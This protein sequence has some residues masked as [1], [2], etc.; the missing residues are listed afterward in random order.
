VRAHFVSLASRNAGRIVSPFVPWAVPYA[1]AAAF[2]ASHMNS[3]DRWWTRITVGNDE[4]D[5]VVPYRSQVYPGQQVVNYRAVD[6]V[7]HTAEADTRLSAR[8]IRRVL[9]LNVGVEVR[10]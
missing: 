1:A 8:S 2:V 7:S 10:R 5:G 6:P 4:G 3:T 9:E